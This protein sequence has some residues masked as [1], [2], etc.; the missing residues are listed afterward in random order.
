[1]DLIGVI[2]KAKDPADEVKISLI[3]TQNDES[4]DQFEKQVE[5]LNNIEFGAA[6]AGIT[7]DYR[8]DPTLHDRS[9]ST[10]TGW[11]IILGRGL[12]FF[13]YSRGDAFELGTRLQEF[14]Q[15]KAF[16]ITYMR[17]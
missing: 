14:R 8:F 6:V 13:Q 9:I 1:M 15:V 3:T 2:A 16:G 7:F 11:F 5:Y 12:D 17:D 4:P 10:D